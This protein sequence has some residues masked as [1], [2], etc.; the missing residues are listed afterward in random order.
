MIELIQIVL[1]LLCAILL[2]V[3]VFVTAYI[4]VTR[5]FYHLVDLAE[6]SSLL[7]GV[8]KPWKMSFKLMHLSP[9]LAVQ[10][11]KMPYFQ[12]LEPAMQRRFESRVARS[13]GKL[14]IL[15]KDG[16]VVTEEMR[17]K[18]CAGLIKLT[19]GYRK[20]IID[21]FKEVW[22]YPGP[23]QSPITRQWHKGETQS[24][25]KV[26]FSWPDLEAGFENPTD[27]LHLGL[28][29]W[30]HALWLALHK[31]KEVDNRLQINHAA[32]DNLLT[33]T[34]NIRRWQKA[35]YLRAYAFTNNMELFACAV[36]SFFETPAQM[37]E[38]HP[39]MYAALAWILN[40][41]FPQL[42]LKTPTL[43]AGV[44]LKPYRL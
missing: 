33:N 21:G 34:E 10:L 32:W 29:E 25:G 4:S 18:V 5:F 1:I 40:Q 35:G 42:K 43:R 17:M 20:Y 27:N 9:S 23:Y 22:L 11:R 30:S 3:L 31:N 16:L 37:A 28:H 36:E 44:H 19:F 38:K 41:D 6:T 24:H 13:M 7:L 12:Q 39:E 14:V 15:G 2:L 8:S 26:L